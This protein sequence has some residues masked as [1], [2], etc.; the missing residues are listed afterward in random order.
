[1]GYVTFLKNKLICPCCVYSYRD[2]MTEQN[3]TSEAE[4]EIKIL[5]DPFF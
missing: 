1:M 5:K 2:D 3:D 4:K